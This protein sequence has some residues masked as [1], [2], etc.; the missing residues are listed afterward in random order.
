MPGMNLAQPSQQQKSVMG[1]KIGRGFIFLIAVVTILLAIWGGLSYYDSRL[2]GEIGDLSARIV[3]NRQGMS[4]DKIDAVTDFQF[5][6]DAVIAGQKVVVDPERLL[7]LVEGNILPGVILSEYS[8]DA[9]SRKI[10]LKGEADSLRSVVQQ[11][12]VLKKMPEVG[13]LSV[14][15]IERNDKGLIGFTFTITL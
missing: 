11:L 13:N 15:S 9:A 8:F 6:M 1:R 10:E 5:R 3:G 14:P 4:Q 2:S 12:T 7:N